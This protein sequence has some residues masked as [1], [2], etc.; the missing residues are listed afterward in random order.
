M[1][2]I[3]WAN[4]MLGRLH[5]CGPLVDPKYNKSSLHRGIEESYAEVNILKDL[6]IMG[7]LLWRS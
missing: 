2:I 5:F 7:V 1:N 6:L 3:Y 4:K